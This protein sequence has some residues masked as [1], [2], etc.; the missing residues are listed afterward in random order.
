MKSNMDIHLLLLKVVQWFQLGGTQGEDFTVSSKTS[1]KYKYRQKYL[2]V[3]PPQPVEIASFPNLLGNRTVTLLPRS[4]L[5][6]DV[7]KAPPIFHK[8]GYCWISAVSI[9]LPNVSGFQR[10]EPKLQQKLQTVPQSP[11]VYGFCRF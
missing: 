2:R 3:F 10:E 9:R 11:N 6:Y 4:N 5:N 1:S 8:L 7:L